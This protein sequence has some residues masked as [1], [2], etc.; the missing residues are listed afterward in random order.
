LLA[1][2][3]QGQIHPLQQLAA[4]QV[5]LDRAGL[6]AYDGDDN[7]TVAIDPATIDPATIDLAAAPPAPPTESTPAPTRPPVDPNDLELTQPFNPF[8]DEPSAP[9]PH[10]PTGGPPPDDFDDDLFERGTE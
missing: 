2:I 4:E 9:P 1:Q 10:R 5:K 7:L 8:A 3:G 6:A